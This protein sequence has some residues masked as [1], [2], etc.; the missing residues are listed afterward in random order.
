MKKR[1]ITA[2]GSMLL[3]AAVPASAAVTETWFTD[4]NA[5]TP[6]N[7]PAGPFLASTGKG[8]FAS[9]TAVLP[10]VGSTA[11]FSEPLV[12]DI[13]LNLIGRA[14]A[15][16]T[17]DATKNFTP[18]FL[19]EMYASNPGTTASDLNVTL[20]GPTGTF[21]KA[22]WV[23]GTPDIA[24]SSGFNPGAGQDGTLLAWHFML[25]SGGGVA[26]TWT[27]TIDN[28]PTT[29]RMILDDVRVSAVP[30][31]S[32]YAMAFAGLGL[33]VAAARRRRKS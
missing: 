9:L 33:L 16:F 19:V 12:G 32:A 4:F 5:A 11:N 7:P 23:A 14:Q 3:A 21:I 2:L 6:N 15:V 10:A 27:L 20:S 13:A 18:S 22:D 24:A 28:L 25:P 8:T 31:P 1:L 29:A 30:E 17:F 26:G